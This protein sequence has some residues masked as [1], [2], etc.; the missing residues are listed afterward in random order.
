MK[1]SNVRWPHNGAAEVAEHVGSFVAKSRSLFCHQCYIMWYMFCVSLS[2]QGN[3]LRCACF[4]L[5]ID[6]SLRLSSEGVV[7]SRP[8]FLFPVFTLCWQT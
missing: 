7:V 3:D 4:M 5:R 1:Q 6:S 8:H 2:D